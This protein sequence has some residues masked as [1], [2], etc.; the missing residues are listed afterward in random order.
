MTGGGRGRGDGAA[1]DLLHCSLY[2]GSVRAC[3]PGRAGVHCTRP[4]AAFPR[5]TVGR[6]DRYCTKIRWPVEPQFPAESRFCRGKWGVC[7][8][9][10]THEGT[11]RPGGRDPGRDRAAGRHDAALPP[12]QDAG[13]AMPP[14][15]SGA[16]GGGDRACIDFPGTMPGA[17]GRGLHD[18]GPR[19]GAPF[20]SLF[21]PILSRRGA[22]RLPCSFSRG[23]NPPRWDWGV[24]AAARRLSRRSSATD[25]AG[26]GDSGPCRGHD[27]ADSRRYSAAG[28]RGVT[29]AGAGVGRSDGP[30][31]WTP[32]GQPSWAET[33]SA[34]VFFPA[35]IGMVLTGMCDGAIA[36]DGPLPGRAQIMRTVF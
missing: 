8:V 1:Q 16:A 28:R 32:A 11:E 19:G 18:A 26:P 25:G 10:T 30:M 5:P 34:G 33:K 6:S 27:A 35:R 31:R 36:P 7:C 21:S 23:P 9:E 20:S 4:A 14:P 12:G 29:P 13:P 15:T 24:R 3:G 2:A 17:L 22:Q